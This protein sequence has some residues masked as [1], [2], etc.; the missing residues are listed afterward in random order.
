[1]VARKQN[2]QYIDRPGGLCTVEWDCSWAQRKRIYISML[3]KKSSMELTV[4]W[5]TIM[6]WDPNVSDRN[7]E[8][9]KSR[10]V[11]PDALPSPLPF[12]VAMVLPQL[13]CTG[14]CMEKHGT[15][16]CLLCRISLFLCKTWCRWTIGAMFLKKL[17]LQ[18]CFME[19]KHDSNA[20]IDRWQKY[21]RVS[22]FF[23]EHGSGHW[24]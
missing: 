11:C 20:R 4:I 9:H 17:S 15:Q 23:V 12:H 2:I 19:K 3:K 1:M 14:N 18:M 21:N 8:M 10:S 7:T 6:H 13:C 24:P 16:Y 22:W 5:E